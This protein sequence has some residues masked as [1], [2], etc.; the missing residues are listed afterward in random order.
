MAAFGRTVYFD[1]IAFGVNVVYITVLAFD[2]YLM[3]E[4]LAGIIHYVDFVCA[5]LFIIETAIR[6]HSLRRNFLLQFWNFFDA[7]SVI[8]VLIGEFDFNSLH[9]IRSLPFIHSKIDMNFDPFSELL[10]LELSAYN[11]ISV[12]LLRVIRILRFTPLFLTH[13]PYLKLGLEALGQSKTAARDLILFLFLIIFVYALIGGVAYK[14]VTNISPINDKI[15]FH[16]VA[17]GFILMLQ[18]ST[19]AGW[20]GLYLALLEHNYSAFGAFVF[21]WSF[22]FI[23]IMILVNLVLT[24]VLN[25][26]K[27]A[28]E[29]ESESTDLRPADWNDFNEKWKVIATP[30]NPHF[31]NKTQLPIL[32]GQLKNSS[33]LRPN[34]TPTEEYIQ[35]LGIPTHNEQLYYGEVLIALNKARLR[36]TQNPNHKK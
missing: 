18:Y 1:W 34:A 22:L 25:F 6:L 11:V 7:V 27:N 33:S 17:Q 23:S 14:Q 2:H 28:C 5:I 36:Q 31:I 19:S 3:I 20:D 10:M 29:A 9:S 13:S 16:S 12:N 15:S 24:I 32:F 4:K 26:Y 30:E 21:L 8:L 35:L